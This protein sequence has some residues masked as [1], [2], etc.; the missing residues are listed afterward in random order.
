[1]GVAVRSDYYSGRVAVITGA[2]SGIGRALAD[3]LSARGA[4]L[5]L[6]DR[7][8]DGLT[9]AAQ[10]CRRVGAR[11]CEQPVDVTDRAAVLSAAGQAYVEF[12]QIDVVLCMAGLIHTGT[13]L[14]SDSADLEHVVRVNVCGTFNTVSALLPYVVESDAGHIVTTSSGFGLMAAP[15]YSAYSASKFA[16]RGFT[17][18]LRQELALDGRSVRATCVVPGG[19]RTP[20]IRNGLFAEGVDADAIIA[21]STRKSHESALSE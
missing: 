21:G 16:V 1:M 5:V 15:R 13:V 9:A 3:D 8:T 7:D 14:E 6:W 20:I 2:A 19:V 18:S 4:R 17:A 10:A 11:V 12:G